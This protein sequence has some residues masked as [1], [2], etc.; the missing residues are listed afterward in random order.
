[1]SNSIPTPA[2]DSTVVLPDGLVSQSS[3][4]EVVSGV[5]ITG[6][7]SSLKNVQ[8]QSPFPQN[9]SLFIS[10][11]VIG[12][13]DQIVGKNGNT[14][15]VFDASNYRIGGWAFTFVWDGYITNSP[16][17]RVHR[18]LDI[19][20]GVITLDSAPDPAANA[21]VWVKDAVFVG[22]VPEGG[23]R[24]N[25]PTKMKPGLVR[26]SGGP[27]RGNEVVGEV[28]FMDASGKLDRPLRLGYQNAL[29]I[30]L[31]LT[32]DVELRDFT[33]LKPVNS[34]SQPVYIKNAKDVRLERMR[35]DGHIGLTTCSRVIIRDCQLSGSI[36]LNGCQDVVV[37]RCQCTNVYLEEECSDIDFID[38]LASGSGTAAFNC[39]EGSPSERLRFTRCIAENCSDMP[40][41]LYGRENELHDCKVRYANPNVASYFNG[42]RL[43]IDGLSSNILVVVKS[44]KNA[45]LTSIRAPLLLGWDGSPAFQPTGTC[46]DCKPDTSRLSPATLAQWSIYASSQPSS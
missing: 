44:G 32:Q 23:L 28:R 37:E 38:V 45:S 42:D 30:Y 27:R 22:S 15:T 10:P 35:I 36:V 7:R 20:A 43:T 11:N 16:R 29:A 21:A 4:L 34:Q 40:W 31:P 5:R 3:G 25:S 17:V 46:V 1:M 39:P 6:P 18:V 9:T 26:I 8:T 12:Y 14:I 24:L 41:C 33:I 13:C 2:P 19:V